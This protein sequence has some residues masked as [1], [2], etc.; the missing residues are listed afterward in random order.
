MGVS[1]GQASIAQVLE[2]DSSQIQRLVASAR[3]ELGGAGQGATPLDACQ[4]ME[5][6][7]ENHAEHLLPQITHTRD[8]FE[9]FYQRCLHDKVLS[10]SPPCSIQGSFSFLLIN[11]SDRNL[12]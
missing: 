12:K 4:L 2:R 6:M 10:C 3:E 8:V 7:H 11:S 9:H 5:T 1:V